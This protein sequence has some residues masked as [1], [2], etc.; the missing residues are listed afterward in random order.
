MVCKSCIKQLTEEKY[1]DVECPEE[2]CDHK[3]PDWE[4]IN[5]LGQE[6]FDKIQG[7]YMKKIVNEDNSLVQCKCGN[8][9]EVL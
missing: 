3:L 4:L 8:A 2:N 1:P 5:I 9:I 7:E 6:D